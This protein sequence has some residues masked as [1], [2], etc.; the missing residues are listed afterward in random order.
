VVPVQKSHSSEVRE[1]LVVAVEHALNHAVQMQVL[2]AI[3]QSARQ[4]LPLAV[5]ANLALLG[6]RYLLLGSRSLS[7]ESETAVAGDFGSV[8]C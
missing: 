1:I 5:S 4:S 8:G 6:S 3:L 2:L 7:R